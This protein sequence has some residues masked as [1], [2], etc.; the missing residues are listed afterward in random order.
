MVEFYKTVFC[1][2]K[3]FQCNRYVLFNKNHFSFVSSGVPRYCS[4][5]YYKGLKCGKGWTQLG[6]ILGFWS[7]KSNPRPTSA[8]YSF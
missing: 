7:L 6:A 4:N 1:S 3:V 5:G 2:I 8:F